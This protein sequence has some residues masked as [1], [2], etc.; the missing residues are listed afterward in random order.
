MIQPAHPIP[1]VD[2]AA[3]ARELADAHLRQESSISR[4]VRLVSNREDDADEP[5]KLLEVNS[6]TFP[7]GIVPIYF[8]TSDSFPVP[9]V[10]IEIT[11]DEFSQLQRNELI[12]PDDWRAG[13]VLYVRQEGAD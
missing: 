13:D 2:K 11:D 3:F 8:G 5:L 10:L 1:K 4:I 12:L 6:E 9:T 7:S